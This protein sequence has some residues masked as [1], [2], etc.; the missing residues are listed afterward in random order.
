MKAYQ[1]KKTF[2]LNCTKKHITEEDY[3]HALTVYDKMGCRT[4]L[5][6]HL[7]YLKT[8]ILLLSDIFENFRKMSID[9]YKLDP[10][11]YIS[12]ASLAWDAMLL[13][14]KINLDLLS[15]PEMLELFERGKRGGLCFVGSKRHVIA[16]NKDIPETYD[17]TKPSNYILYLDANNLYGWAM[18]QF[19]PKGGFKW[20]DDINLEKILET[21]DNAKRGFQLEVDLEF[22]PEIHDKL[23]E[24]PPAPENVTP[25]YAWFSD[26]Q[27]KLYQKVTTNKQKVTGNNQNSNNNEFKYTGCNK[28]VPHLFKHEKYSIHYRNLKFLHNLGVKITKVHRVVSYKQ[29]NWLEPYIDFD[30]KKRKEAKTEFEK[31]LFKLMN[32]SVFGKTMENVK[33]RVNIHATTSDKNAIKWFSK[34]NLKNAKYFSGLYLIEMYKKEIVYDKPLYVGTSILDLSKLRMMEFHYDVMRKEFDNTFDLIFR[35]W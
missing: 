23:K 2:I 25:D 33:N 26:F 24:F 32:N 13:N 9:Y 19:L 35:Y 29:S 11:N 21:K 28:L 20:V 34:V 27:K 1:N 5:D 10:A 12:A 17:K 14:T 18:V 22:P 4:F 30:T 15:D 3:K 31:D 8:D 16:N 7:L 6:Y